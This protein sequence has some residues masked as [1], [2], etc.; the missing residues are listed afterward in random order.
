[1]DTLTRGEIMAARGYD[2]PDQ[3]ETTEAA[4]P[5]WP[6]PAAGP[7]DVAEPQRRCTECGDGIDGLHHLRKICLR[8]KCK[9]A[10]TNRT[11]AKK[12]SRTTK[13]CT[14]EPEPAE[15]PT[16]NDG[17]IEEL[18]DLERLGGEFV[19]ACAA[20]RAAR[21]R[22]VELQAVLLAEISS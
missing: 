17:A 19:E 5:I 8:E 18:A 4:D 20:E 16:G 14:A 9:R 1:M 10:R 21:A 12:R 13:P 7:A 3:T 22:R 15:P 2:E 11:Q 6:K